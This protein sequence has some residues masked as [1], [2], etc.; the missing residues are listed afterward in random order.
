MGSIAD[1][2]VLIRLMRRCPP[3]GH[4]DDRLD[5]SWRSCLG[6]TWTL[7]RVR[8]GRPGEG[9]QVSRARVRSDV[10]ARAWLL[11]PM[12]VVAAAGGTAAQDPDARRRPPATPEQ[13]LT[14][15]LPAEP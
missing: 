3:N 7:A 13:H 8:P 2:S 10:A 6:P 1:W 14:W 15:A 5:Q 12:V 11:P 4:A 9:R